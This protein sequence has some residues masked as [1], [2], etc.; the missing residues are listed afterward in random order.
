MFKNNE[1][2][3]WA[4][5]SNINT[6]E[7]QLGNL[8]LKDLKK[9]NKV[10]LIRNNFFRK[11][12]SFFHKYLL[13]Y[14]GIF[15][16]WLYYYC[17]KKICYLNYLPFWNFLIFLLI[18]PKT[19]LGPI[20]GGAITNKKK[21]NIIRDFIFPIFYFFSEI[22][23]KLRRKKILFATDLVKKYL[24]YSNS[25]NYFWNYQLKKID[26]IKYNYIKKDID[27][28]IYNRI[29]SN[30]EKSL[31]EKILNKI[32]KKKKIYI[33]GD[34]IY[35]PCVRNLGYVSNIKINKLLERTKFSIVT[36]ENIFSFFIMES[37]KNNVIT[38]YDKKMKKIQYLR[39]FFID[40]RSFNFHKSF[41]VNNEYIKKEQKKLQKLFKRNNYFFKNI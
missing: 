32:D 8:F 38:I 20:T 16:L 22:I 2:Y 7:G 1:I 18:P 15:K 21:L 40:F 24:I 25:S 33:V 36:S 26:K 10:I 37:I 29:H 9:K 34:I 19:I 23:L 4:C 30:K 12:N 5:D 31:I 14:V 35:N 28:L 27:F 6:G 41:T 11:K 39:K 13:P 17:N 3:V